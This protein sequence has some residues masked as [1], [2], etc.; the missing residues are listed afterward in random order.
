M[1][2]NLLILSTL[3]FPFWAV[4]QESNQYEYGK[5][6]Q[7]DMDYKFCEYDKNAEAA[8]L[9][10]IGESHFTRVDNGFEMIHERTTR[11]KIFT[12]KGVEE[13]SQ[14]VIPYYQH[15]NIYEKVYDIEG[16]TYNIS[17]NELSKTPI[18]VENIQNEKISDVNYCKKIAIANVKAGSVI[19]YRYKINTQYLFSLSWDFQ[20]KIPVLYSKYI[21]NMLPFYTYTFLLQGSNNFD[22][23]T[24]KIDNIEQQFGSV[25]YNEMAYTYVKKNIPAFNDE[26]F[27]SSAEDYILKLI[28]QLCKI[29][30]P[31]GY[32]KEIITTWPQMVKDMIEDDNYGKYIKKAEKMAE[33][34]IDVKSI[35][36][37]PSL[38]RFDTVINYVKQNYTWDQYRRIYST[39]SVKD[40]ISSKL[41][42]SADLNLFTIG[43]L[44]AVGIKTYPVMIST[45]DHGK[46]WNEYPFFNFF[47]YSVILSMIDSVP[48]LSDVTNRYLQN[49]RIPMYCIN[50]KGLIVQ[51]EKTSW[52]NMYRDFPN[53]ERT[54]FD[55]QLN[56]NE[57]K[58][59]ANIQ[60][61]EYAAA[62]FRKEYGNDINSIKKLLEKNQYTVQDSTIKVSNVTD[63]K[64]PYIICF[65]FNTEQ[66]QINDK[67]YISPFANEVVKN[68]PFKQ[69]NRT[70]IIDMTIARQKTYIS[71]INI[72]DGYKIDY[73][74]QNQKID[75]D[76]FRMEYS[77]YVNENLLTVSFIYYFKKSTY[78]AT[79][80]DKLKFYYKEIINRG[81]EKIVLTKLSK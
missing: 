36:Q 81:L 55:I 5:I 45:R 48:V 2:K 74:P 66:E 8:V 49:N 18:N 26:E 59:N 64:K 19:E 71:H 42:N 67:L 68:N 7:A 62:N 46:I 35:S 17:E 1:K 80:Y 6:R 78:P 51:Q 53:K 3:L 37:L 33:K 14:L 56:G 70:Y 34:V 57:V 40:L 31:G 12:E 28:F 41:G 75:N 30:F 25:K 44:N 69:D 29:T 11:I 13:Y 58:Y 61:H 65:Q 79:E 16:C 47:N 39:K 22:E 24:S 10:D 60:M 50:D 38:Q 15:N 9:F 77:T 73:L 23:Q 63:L 76:S 21:V 52:V 32:Q 20:W 27:I 4:C 54:T 43:L 72:P